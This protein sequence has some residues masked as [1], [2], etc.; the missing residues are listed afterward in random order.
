MKITVPED[1]IHI[2]PRKSNVWA[3]IREIVNTEN[4]E[5]AFYVCDV[6]DIISKDN[7]WKSKLPRV[8]PHYGKY[9]DQGYFAFVLEGISMIEM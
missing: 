1:N 8:K 4:R 5:D 2:V 3:T 7:I 9:F 6:T